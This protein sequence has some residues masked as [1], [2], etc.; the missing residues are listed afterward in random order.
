MLG[1]GH[2]ALVTGQVPPGSGCKATVM[3]IGCIADLL[4]L[5]SNSGVEGAPQF[6]RERAGQR[7]ALRRGPPEAARE[8]AGR[9]P[10]GMAARRLRGAHGARGG[11]HERV[12]L[13]DRRG[14]GADAF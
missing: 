9:F 2:D 6:E 14:V 4:M 10:L 12:V 11:A 13:V 7:L 1:S 5:R 3:S 8:G